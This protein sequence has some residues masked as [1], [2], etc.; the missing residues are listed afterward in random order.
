M[1]LFASMVSS[2]I[3]ISLLIACAAQPVPNGSNPTSTG[4]SGVKEPSADELKALAMSYTKLPALNTDLKQSPMHGGVYVR[5]HLDEAANAAYQKKQF[6][7]PDGATAFK[8]AHGSLTG[9]IDRIYVMR[10]IKDYD[11]ANKDWYYAV[12]SPE[13]TVRQSGKI[14]MCISCHDKYQAKD[15]IAGFDN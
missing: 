10:K 5:T 1:K 13:G 11:P 9:P 3:C 14:G 12:L 15:Y 4:M 2:S 8:Q 6:P 7:Y